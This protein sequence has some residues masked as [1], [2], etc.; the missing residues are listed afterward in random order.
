MWSHTDLNL[1]WED[2]SMNFVGNILEFSILD[3]WE[4]VPKV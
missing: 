2:K 4:L 3:H 1:Y